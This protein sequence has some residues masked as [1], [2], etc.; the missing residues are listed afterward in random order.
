[1]LWARVNEEKYISKI[2]KRGKRIKRL[3]FEAAI[4]LKD[5]SFFITDYA[6]YAD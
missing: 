5:R 3:I 1:M 4:K 6:D 2:E